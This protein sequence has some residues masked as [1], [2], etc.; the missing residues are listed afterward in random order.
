MNPFRLLFALFILVPLVEIYLLVQV[1]SMIGAMPT[2]LLVVGTALVG[3]TLLRAQ[4]LST[5][6]EAQRSL[7]SGEIP[8]FQLLEGAA[9]L[10]SGALLLTPGFVTDF[11]GFLGL[12]PSTRKILVNRFL[13]RSAQ[14]GAGFHSYTSHATRRDETTI[15]G[16]FH[17]KDDPWLK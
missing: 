16:E 14:V 11:I 7:A 12:I 17:E 9:L 8:A 5:W 3:V 15:E 13:S 10:V 2:V 1:G 6:M 4:G